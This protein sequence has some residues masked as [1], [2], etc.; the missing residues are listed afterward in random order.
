MRNEGR[1]RAFKVARSGP[2]GMLDAA[3][4][5]RHGADAAP[6]WVLLLAAKVAPDWVASSRVETLC[7]SAPGPL[8]DTERQMAL[9]TNE[10]LSACHPTIPPP[11]DGEPNPGACSHNQISS[12][13]KASE[14]TAGPFS[15]YSITDAAGRNYLWVPAPAPVPA[16]PPPWWASSYRVASC[17]RSSKTKITRRT[18]LFLSPISLFSL[19]LVLKVRRGGRHSG[20]SLRLFA[21]EE[22]PHTLRLG[23]HGASHTIRGWLGG[24]LLR[25]APVQSL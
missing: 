8:T 10:I 20:H 16:A 5:M 13:Q 21:V 25:P 24:F 12:H 1:C 19:S 11:P 17:K 4:G 23:L 3:R 14:Q 9:P 2:M 18:Q 7:K 22:A 15:W 6:V